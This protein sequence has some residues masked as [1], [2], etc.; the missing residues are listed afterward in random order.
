MNRNTITTDTWSNDDSKQLYEL[1]WPDEPALKHQYE[2]GQQCGGCSFYAEFDADYGLCCNPESRHYLETVFEHFTCPTSVQ[3]GWGP[4][5]FTQD[6]EF[7]CHCG[8]ERLNDA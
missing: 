8:G 7:H 3:E 2:S 4:H 5:S 1:G 6:S